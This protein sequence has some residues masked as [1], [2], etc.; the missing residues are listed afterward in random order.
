VA[1]GVVACLLIGLADWLPEAIPRT[2]ASRLKRL[3]QAKRTM[4]TAPKIP[5]YQANG[6]N[7]LVWK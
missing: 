3:G 1:P 6:V 2:S 7:V 4:Q 5:Q